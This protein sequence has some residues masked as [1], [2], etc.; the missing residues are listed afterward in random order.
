MARMWWNILAI[1]VEIVMGLK[2]PGEDG[3]WLFGIRTVLPTLNSDGGVDEKSQRLNR[4]VS[5]LIVIFFK[6]SLLIP[7]GPAAPS[8]VFFKANSVSCSVMGI[9]S[10]IGG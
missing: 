3:F 6:S 7:S 5:S 9:S 4:R 10:N 8:F 1:I 2:S